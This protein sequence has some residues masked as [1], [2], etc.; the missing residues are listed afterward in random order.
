MYK[1]YLKTA[2]RS[3][4]KHK[5]FSLINVIG[6]AIGISASLVIYLIVSYDFG[7]D[8]FHPDGDRIYRVVSNFSY[9][10]EPF[11][12]SGVPV[13]VGPSVK[14]G[15]TGIEVVA[16]LYGYA[17][18]GK[19]TVDSA[20]GTP[21]VIK[22]Q[23]HI[24]ITDGAYFDLINYK[25]LTG[26]RQQ[27]FAHPNQVVLTAKQAKLYFPNLDYAAIMGK[28]V[29]YEDSLRT[30]VSGIVEDLQG[31]TDFNF[32]DFISLKTADTHKNLINNYDKP[33]WNSTSSSDQLL[34]KL[35][36]NAVL[37][38]VKKQI[39]Q[40]YTKNHSTK[41]ESPGQKHEFGMQ[42]L[43]DI[44]F[45]ANYDTFDQRQ[46][47][48]TVLYSL[49]GV[50]SFLLI[51]G[52]INFINLTT[53]QSVQRAKEIGVRK[54][55][56]G[57]RQQ[58]IGQFLT[59]TF[60]L[61]VTATLLS[62]LIAYCLIQ[63]FG[64]FIPKE[65]TYSMLFTKEIFLFMVM[66]VIVITVAA[67]LYPAVML[68]SFKP[69]HVLKGYDTAGKS[70]GTYLRKTLT[71]TQFVIAQFFIM[72]TLMVG[73]QIHYVLS[74]DLGFEKNSILFI[75]TPWK[76]S[77]TNKKEVLAEKL[78]G[79]PQVQQTAVGGSSPSASSTWSTYMKYKDG[80]KETETEVFIKNGDEHYMDVYK[81]RLLAGRKIEARDT[82]QKALVINE[83]Y[84][85]ILGFKEPKNAVGKM[86][87]WDEKNVPIVGVVKDFYQKSLHTAIKP[88]AII[89]NKHANYYNVHV[90]L[91]PQNGKSWS[92]AIA[93]MQKAWK[94][95]FPEEEFSYTFVDESVAKFYKAEQDTSKLLNWATGL[96][97]LISCMGL[98][99]LAIHSTN[100]RVKEIGVRK[101]LGASV[102]QIVT[103][104]SADF[105][106][107]IVIAFVLSLPVA[108]YAM[109]QWLQRFAYHA[110]ISWWIFAGA[111]ASTLII[112]LFTMSLQT[113]KAALANPVKSL[114]S[115]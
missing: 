47:N 38:N 79:I 51:L 96:S 33:S 98:L 77:N 19:I 7:F 60:V 57:T 100:Q 82:A 78:S 8:K 59:E 71:I 3:L 53:A 14:A 110:Q 15:V 10:G 99:G 102:S 114:R 68:S 40:L 104:L 66:L 54:T 41:D 113:V 63:L 5:I 32:H 91:K 112:A 94:E 80:K 95:V 11:Y 50:A 49:L 109:H 46:A 58:L 25:W 83:T 74:K 39:D 75:N 64:N 1:N 34:I 31:R 86:I 73:S 29:T 76:A 16:P 84:A 65:I 87:N 22:N 26:S 88:V 48:K 17:Q 67:G 105:V 9:Q 21:K 20:N 37:A 28:Q 115:E 69:I 45:N 89:T 4:L 12:N 62:A 108:W 111:I 72:G 93:Q 90:A 43:N 18:E 70:R 13:V 44:H 85:R 97:I 30:T 24:V 27:A 42:P 35:A 81:L 101:V 106:K 107:L 23:E 56:G 36:P 52:C 92:A 61:T 2:L 6:L 55:I 103:L